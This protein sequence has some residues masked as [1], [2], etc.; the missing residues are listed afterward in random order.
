MAQ[1]FL[2]KNSY[3]DR[4]KPATF[5]IRKSD[6]NCRGTSLAL[7]TNHWR[8]KMVRKI[9]LTGAIV[10]FI[11]GAGGCSRNQNQAELSVPAKTPEGVSVKSIVQFVESIDGNT[12]ALE[13]EITNE[14]KGAV[15]RLRLLSENGTPVTPDPFARGHHAS[16]LFLNPEGNYEFVTYESSLDK[17][18]LPLI[19]SV[20]RSTLR[21]GIKNELTIVN[22]IRLPNF[23]LNLPMYRSGRSLDQNLRQT[24]RRKLSKLYLDDFSR[25]AI[26]TGPSLVKDQGSTSL[27]VNHGAEAALVSLG[28]Q[29]VTPI[30]P[31]DIDDVNAPEVILCPDLSGGDTHYIFAGNAEQ[32]GAVYAML[33]ETPRPSSETNRILVVTTHGQKAELRMEIPVAEPEVHINVAVYDGHSFYFGGGA[34]RVEKGQRREPAWLGRFTNGTLTES[35]YRIPGFAFISALN[36]DKSNGNIYAGGSFDFYQA[37]SGSLSDMKG[38]VLAVDAHLKRTQFA[39]LMGARTTRVVVVKHIVQPGRSYLL[40]GGSTNGPDTHSGDRHAESFLQ[41]ISL[42]PQQP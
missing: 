13:K 31:L 20:N 12:L 22:G 34:Q 33:N 26:Y 7:A 16:N 32:L 23:S 15:S 19:S 17:N 39:P 38:F 25:P 21:I 14:K 9:F 5:G 42:V 8:K 2:R 3:R 37:E 10:G 29:P 36:V 28:G 27:L 41:K 24:A 40:A 4:Y 35:I 6:K 30:R 1:L 11:L 18:A